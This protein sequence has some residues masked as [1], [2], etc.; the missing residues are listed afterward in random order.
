MNVKIRLSILLVTWLSPALAGGQESETDYKIGASQW[1]LSE[2]RFQLFEDELS[3]YLYGETDFRSLLNQPALSIAQQPTH[4]EIASEVALASYD[5]SIDTDRSDDSIENSLLDELMPPMEILAFEWPAVSHGRSILASNSIAELQ[6]VVDEERMSVEEDTH[7]TDSQRAARLQQ[8][9]AA[10]EWLQKANQYQRRIQLYANQTAESNQAS[11][12][13]RRLLSE[14]IDPAEP[15]NVSSGIEVTSVLLYRELQGKRAQLAAQKSEID[16]YTQAIKTLGDRITEIPRERAE[17]TT[18]LQQI[19]EAIEHNEDVE[20]ELPGTTE[21]NSEIRLLLQYARKRA[22]ELELKMLDAE[23]EQQEV[24]G[25]MFPIKRDLASREIAKLEAEIARWEV[26]ARETRKAEDRREA[27]MAREASLNAH[28]QLRE[29]ASRNQVLVEERSQLYDK[30]KKLESEIEGTK[31]QFDS[32]IEQVQSVQ[33]KIEAAGLSNETGMLLVNMRRTLLSS[34]ESHVRIPEVQEEMKEVNLQV[35]ALTEEREQ[36]SQPQKLIETEIGISSDEQELFQMANEFVDAKRSYLDQLLSDYRIYR[37][38][39]ADASVER[40]KLI[41][42]LDA[43]TKYINENALWI[44]STSAINLA[45]FSEAT[46]AAR[47]FAEPEKWTGMFNAA[48]EKGN[49]KPMGTAFVG[50]GLFL[51]FVFNFKLR[52]SLKQRINR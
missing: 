43:T 15:G 18:R 48:I 12:E 45:D 35:V 11:E 21:S 36:L 42:E 19:D 8:L 33:G 6:A 52:S 17:A 3:Y 24:A 10:D 47:F 44:R 37:G 32:V 46:E 51:L 22:T 26:A 9:S 4:N 50:M 27:A 7:N 13:K 41:D 30:L 39:L 16:Q 49:S 2:Q 14:P 31:N 38:M 40:R 5:E 29:W 25:K 23:V 28:P 20:N 34:D 1:N